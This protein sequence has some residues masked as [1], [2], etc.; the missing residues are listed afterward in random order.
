MSAPRLLWIGTYTP[1]S[2]PEA[3]GEGIH[4]AWLDPAT[5][6][7][8]GGAAAARTAGPSF[9]AAH[10][11][12]GVLY[13]VNEVGRGTVE[14]FAV[15]TDDGGAPV[16]TALGGVPTGGASPCHVLAHPGGDRVVTANYADGRV[17]VHPL[18]A[19]TGAVR[20]PDVVLAHTGAGPDPERQEGPHAHSAAIAPGGRHILVADLG[21]DELRC[22]TFDPAAVRP[23]GPV[24]PLAVAAHLPPGT[25][26][27]HMALHPDGRVYVAGELDSRVHVLSWDAERARAAPVADAAASGHEGPNHPGEI[28]LSPD[29]ERL[30]VSNRG[31]DTIATFE[32]TGGGTGLRRIAETPCGGAWPRHF[33]LTDG[34]IVVANQKSAEL[35][36]LRLDDRG[37][38]EDTGHR[39]AVGDP[40]CVLPV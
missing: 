36:S 15:E 28:A 22:H 32:I 31:A 2:D 4:R 17:S 3:T 1:G 25:G 38:P 26:P 12:G 35:S 21:T 23:V 24:G 30:Y 8:H 10:P 20:E 14:A 29:G 6:R 34:H 16:L 13:A 39:L 18:A 19:D 9:L 11:R 40:A 7:L 33:A 37:V 27:R 5:G